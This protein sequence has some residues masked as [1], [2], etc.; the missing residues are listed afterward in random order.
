MKPVVAAAPADHHLQGA[1]TSLLPLGFCSGHPRI[2]I[3]LQQQRGGAQLI[4]AGRRAGL[5]VIALNAAIAPARRS[6]Q[7]IKSADALHLLQ[8][9]AF[10]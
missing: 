1:V 9:R 2:V 3:G 10:S 6:N 5:L 4:Q 7:I 8:P